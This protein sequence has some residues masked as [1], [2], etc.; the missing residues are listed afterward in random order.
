MG[1][2]AARYGDR[3]DPLEYS[4]GF[5]AEQYQSEFI[6]SIKG[7]T[8]AVYARLFKQTLF[9]DNSLC[10]SRSS[11]PTFK[12]FY[13]ARRQDW[14]RWMCR[15][16]TDL[17][18]YDGEYIIAPEGGG[19]ALT[20]DI[21]YHVDEKTGKPITRQP[22]VFDMGHAV[23]EA[24]VSGKGRDLFGKSLQL[25]RSGA[26]LTPEDP[27]LPMVQ[28][29]PANP[30]RRSDGKYTRL[31]AHMERLVAEEYGLHREFTHGYSWHG[32]GTPWRPVESL[33]WQNRMRRLSKQAQRRTRHISV[34]AFRKHEA[35]S[36]DR[37]VRNNRSMTMPYLIADIDTSGPK[38]SLEYVDLMLARLERLGA[39]PADIIV[40][41]TGG[42]GFHVRIPAGL[43]GNPIFRDAT[44]AS[45]VVR[46]F[47]ELIFDGREGAEGEV[48]DVIDSAKFS[49]NTLIRSIGSVH[50]K[51][52][53]W[54]V[55]FTGEEIRETPLWKIIE[56]S[57]NT[58]QP[59]APLSDPSE[60]QAAPELSAAME[61]AG[62]QIADQETAGAGEQ[63]RGIIERIE[64]Q[65]VSK[66]E[67]F[68]PGYVGRNYAALLL[69]LYYI[70]RLPEKEA[71]ERVY[72]WNRQN[73]TP[74]G[75]HPEDDK[76]ELYYVFHRA[77]Q[78]AFTGEKTSVTQ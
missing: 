41:Y 68:A 51:T 49:P 77:K 5:E 43:V 62:D 39:D 58:H 45:R 69:S 23:S 3:T 47:F 21:V 55:G 18:R 71:W 57:K 26:T 29:T 4:Q 10:D 74:L 24:D 14:N 70:Q 28:C 33:P 8:R 64:T 75:E 35:Q 9:P 78:Y 63:S 20:S 12:Q 31:M 2:L 65:G 13:D 1:V 16:G 67:E 44:A 50:E 17:P 42:K 72:Q 19:S 61:V 11:A 66:G 36:K 59:I 15:K 40:S 7:I 34:G 76:N 22:L 54:C 25:N 37:R 30:P 38:R 32:K 53:R 46:R 52:G 73:P 27:P 60:V 48:M 56:L 6:G